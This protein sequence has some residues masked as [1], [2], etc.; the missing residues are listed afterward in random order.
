MINLERFER[1]W[2]LLT[3]AAVMMGWAKVLKLFVNNWDKILAPTTTTI[4]TFSGPAHVC[5]SKLD[6]TIRLAIIIS[7]LEF[8]NALIGYT[9]SKPHYV[10]L[11]CMIRAIVELLVAPMLL[12]I[13]NHWSHIFTVLCWSIGDTI[14]FFC[15]VIDGLVPGGRL[16]KKIRY[17]VGPILFP[18]GAAGEMIMVATLAYQKQS[19]VLYIIAAL[20][21]VGFKPLFLS[22]LA[23]RKKFMAQEKKDKEEK[24]D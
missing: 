12:P 4:T 16:M 24:E 19:Y 17:T 13:C 7:F 11:F 23:N 1:A 15:F 18:L 10:L 9:K 21:V 14:R 22:L 3:N 8:F 6:P 2:M 5:L 20:W